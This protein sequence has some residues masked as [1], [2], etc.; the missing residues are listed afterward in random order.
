[1]TI[2]DRLRAFVPGKSLFHADLLTAHEPQRQERGTPMPRCATARPA[3]H[4]S[5]AL[6]FLGSVVAIA[7]LGAG[8]KTTPT[9]KTEPIFFPPAPDEPRIQYLTAFGSETDLGAASKFTTFVVGEEKVHRPIWK[10]YGVAVTKDTVYV[11]DTQAA[12]L[13][14]VD[15]V[16][17]RIRY[18]RP[19]GRE[20]MQTPINVAVDGQGHRYV[21]D[22]QRGQ[23]LIYNQEG[24]RIGEIGRMGEMK[25]C[26]VFVSGERLY[27]SDLASHSV[28]V[29]AL[30]GRQ[31]LMTI[32][33]DPKDEKAKLHSPTNLAIDHQENI[34]VSDT[35]GFVAKV[36]DK[37]GK[38]LRTV[39]DLGLT[40]GTFTLPK[41]IAVDRERRMYVV[42]GATA[43]VQMFDAEGRLLMFFG[44]PKSSGPA[45]LYLPAGI[46]VDY[47]NVPLFQKYVAPGFKLEHLIFITNQAGRNKVSVYGFVKKG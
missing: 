17:R 26:G 25:P 1:M 36:F 6:R 31:L 5:A 45:G 10:P 43:V 2:S 34:Y 21:T 39:G 7:V 16:K 46:A 14:I 33:G 20:A 4:R 41:G 44:E 12:N 32:P 35:G 15:L 40:A 30:P 22:T 18:I 24:R 29:Y 13:G 37:S 19:S 27:V 42:D 11:C 9:Q 3:R 23:V 47:E 8:C 28:K 38:H